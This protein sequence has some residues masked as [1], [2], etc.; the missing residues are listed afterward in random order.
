M[1]DQIFESGHEACCFAFAADH[2]QYPISVIAKLMGIDCGG[3]GKGLAGLD[4]R[5]IAGTIKRHVATLRQPYPDIIGARYEEDRKNAIRHMANIAIYIIKNREP[6]TRNDALVFELVMYYFKDTNLD[7][8]NIKLTNI[9]D[10][11]SCHASTISR[12][13]KTT[14]KIILHWESQAQAEIDTSLVDHGVI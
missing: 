3:S 1:V 4:G 5:S 8:N 2:H 14:R 10:K 13:W 12:A 9:A 7:G 11:Y 6:I